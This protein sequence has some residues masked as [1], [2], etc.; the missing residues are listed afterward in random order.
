MLALDRAALR[1]RYACRWYFSCGVIFLCV[2]ARMWGEHHISTHYPQ[3]LDDTGRVPLHRLPP[4]YRTLC[5]TVMATM[6][7]ATVYNIWAFILIAKHTL[8]MRA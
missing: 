7:A 1:R 5:V 6:L 3:V 4:F 8:K 2:V